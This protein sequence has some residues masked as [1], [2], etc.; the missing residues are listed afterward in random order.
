MDNFTNRIAK[1]SPAKRNLFERALTERGR[2][3]LAEPGIPRAHTADPVPLS[4]AQQRLW[5]LDQLE[6]DSSAYNQPKAVR[7]SGALNVEALQKALDAIVCRHEVLRTT[8]TLVDGGTAVQSVGQNRS[9]DFPLI[10]LSSCPDDKRNEELQRAITEISEQRFDLSRDLMIRAALFRLAPS[11]HVFLLVTHH[12]ATDGWSGG[13]LWRELALLYAAFSTGEPDP[14][15]ELPV[16]YAD[17]AVWQRSYLQGE[18]LEKQLS[19][20]KKQ[21]S[22]VPV[23]ELPVDRPRPAV[24]SY[25][26]AR[27]SFAISKTVSEKLKTLSRNHGVTLFMTLLAA[28]QTLLHRYTGQED[29]A[30]GSVIANRTRAEIE[31]LIGFFV[32]TLVLRADL[33][34]NP[35]FRE[36]MARVRKVALEA[37]GHQDLPFEK[38]VEEFNPDRKLS[39]TPLFQVMFVFQNAPRSDLELRGLEVK[40]VRTNSDTAKFDLTLSVVEEAGELKASLEYNTDLFEA[41]TIARML[42]HFQRLLKDIVADPERRLSE[43]AILTE[44]E[45]R[46]IVVEWNDTGRVYPKDKCIHELFEAQVERTPDALA[47]VFED[48]QL[49]YRELNAK[50]NQLAH[51]LKKRGVGLEVLVGLCVERSVEMV[52]AL[53]AIVKGGGAYVPLDPQYPKERLKFMLEDTRASIIVT[54]RRLRDRLP[55]HEATVVYLD[56]EAAWATELDEN[57]V[58]AISPENLLYVM[59]TSGSTGTPKGVSVVHRGVVRLVKNTDYAELTSDEVFLQFAPISFDASTFEIWGALL[60]GA[61]CVLFPGSL[62]TPKELGEILHRHS[63]STLWLT[64]SLFNAI[65]DEAPE[66][67]ANVRQLLVGGEALSVPHVRNALTHLSGAQIING[68]GPTESTT[69][70]CCYPVARDLS[71]IQSSIPIGRPIANTQVFVLDRHLRPVPVG[72]AGEL[73]IGGDGLA[74]GYLNR[75]ES[76]AEKFIPNPFNSE[77]GARLYRT[78]DLVRYLPDGNIGFLGRTDHQVKI[79]GFRIELGEI[80]AVLLQHPAVRQA[81]VVVREDSEDSTE[82][83]RLAAYVVAKNAALTAQAL[84]VFLRERL[85]EYMVPSDF[86]FLRALPLTPNGKVDRE[87]LPVPNPIGHENGRMFSAPRDNVEY[88]MAKIWEDILGVRPVGVN[89]NFFELGGHSLLAVRL[90]ARVEKEF[91]RAVP[92]AALFAGPTIDKLAD[93]VRHGGEALKWN[94]LFPIQST[95][96]K[97]PLF[98]LHGSGELGR[99]LGMD[100]PVYGGRTHGLDGRW[101]PASVEKM[102]AD[103]VKEIRMAQPEGP[104]FVGGYCFGGLLAF[105]V[106]RQLR[107]RDQEVALLVLLDPTTPGKGAAGFAVSSSLP[108]AAITRLAEQVR[109]HSRKLW[110]LRVQERLARVGRSVQ[111]RFNSVKTRLARRVDR[112]IKMLACRALLG[113]GRLV[114]EALR[115][116]YFLE[117][118]RRAARNYVPKVY[119]GRVVLLRAEN[120]VENSSVEWKRLVA[121]KLEIYKLPSEY[122][123]DP[124]EGP[125]T[126][127]WAERVRA[128]LQNAQTNVSD[129]SS[130]GSNS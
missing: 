19:Y 78:G 31:G 25:Q 83:K 117:V 44:A 100:Q 55:S 65:V 3:G 8:F 34:G 15:P 97:P 68:Y 99:Q 17:Y 64:A 94:W 107:E 29:I 74:R 22:G 40:S 56:D 119:S 93:L 9:V 7:L 75:P 104:Y 88:R 95:G 37:Y 20:W 5:F 36:V 91:N 108:Q 23:L 12:I 77:P 73:C 59:Y 42:G 96:S 122:H 69:F 81:L 47:V 26:G 32:N 87:R 76:T 111:W 106:A 84:G 89:D 16:Q 49:T 38:L 85:P 51:Y 24:Q 110:P 46:Q 14:L 116:F 35:S 70:T 86:V 118:S 39:R 126:Q 102:A 98:L 109:R 67:L 125:H 80:E 57:L 21:L 4:F 120:A 62:S 61:R 71:G 115:M 130:P 101:A 54:Q 79:R 92:L 66:V 114:P 58:A 45:R 13:I 33:S 48:R 128:C 2:G 6:P 121:G 52:V 82:R 112:S 103:Y 27:L 41:G 105:E 53:L 63:V 124:I 127:A 60:H 28:F 50:A 11:E 10:D 1:L 30:V 129:D 18:V 90:L 43:L 113:F 72:V 123:M